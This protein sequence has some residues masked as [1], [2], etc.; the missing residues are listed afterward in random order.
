MLIDTSGK[1]QP[2]GFEIR[3]IHCHSVQTLPRLTM[4]FSTQQRTSGQERGRRAE[5]VASWFFRLNG[6]LAIPGF[7]VHLDSASSHQGEDGEPRIA[8]TEADLMAVRFPFS[9]EV[10]GSREM[11]DAQ[12]LTRLQS[13]DNE[14]KPLFVLV[15]VKASLC[16]MN[17][18]WTNRQAA[19][20]QRVLRRLGF[21]RDERIIHSAAA[22]L[23]EHARWEGGSVLVQYICVGGQKSSELAT[24]YDQL[25]QIDWRQIGEFMF[26]RFSSHPEKTPSGLVHDQ[27]PKFGREFGRWFVGGGKQRGQME[28]GRA[29][30]RYVRDGRLQ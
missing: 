22:A 20:M 19:N 7:I 2:F 25:I 16:K 17:G 21:T 28:A 26:E 18:P 29:V 30:E 5:D 9:R 8:R 14:R 1:K 4:P 12:E 11:R 10:V 13:G 3:K 23:Y 15:E 27:W 24:M 6:F